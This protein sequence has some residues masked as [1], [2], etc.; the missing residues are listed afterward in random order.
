MSQK[1]SL[2]SGVDGLPQAFF[3]NCACSLSV[4]LSIIFTKSYRLGTIPNSWRSAN[5]TPIYKGSGSAHSPNNYRPIS[6]TCIASK[7]MELIVRDNILT[8][9][10]SND[11]ISH[12]QHGFLPGKSTTSQLIETLND[13]TLSLDSG[14]NIDCIYLDFS[15]AF[16]CISHSR[17]ISKI[18]AYGIDNTT[19]G[20]I[21][22]FLH[23]RRQRVKLNGTFSD[24]VPCLSGVP[25]GS[26][27]GPLLFVIFTDDL[28]DI[29]LNAKIKMYADDV[30]LYLPVCDITSHALLQD[31][32]NRISVWASTWQLKLNEKKCILLRLKSNLVLPSY[33][34]N[35]ILLS[36]PDHVKD[37]GVYI[38]PKLDFTYHCNHIA[39]IAFRRCYL[40]LNAFVTRD[41]DF[42]LHMYVSYVRPLLEFSSQV[43]SPHLLS[44]I[45]KI[46]SVQRHFTKS[47]P[48]LKDLSYPER[49]S[50]LNLQSLEVRR[51]RSDCVLLQKMRLGYVDISFDSLFTPQSFIASRRDLRSGENVL[52]IPASHLNLRTFSYPVRTA[53]LWNSLPVSVTSNNPSIAVFKNCL[54]DTHVLPFVRGRAL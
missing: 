21:R 50:A 54:L 29:V 11:L 19:I 46:K 30:K 24:W 22:D 1:N 49:L 43:W 44:N 28:P 23:N 41:H 48:G 39:N 53:R 9:L 18:S 12:S 7:V 6:L 3:K 10:R 2:T 32:L 4:P 42:L 5:I 27:L 35:D 25:Q 15:K 14:K 20:W 40:L 52:H 38:T 33:V 37:L 47:F 13:W 51:L 45:D 17:L 26:V 31:D 16:G 34:L 36:M 8:F